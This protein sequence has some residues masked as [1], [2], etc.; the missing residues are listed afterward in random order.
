MIVLLQ[1][2]K[3]S[4]VEFKY[5]DKWGYVCSAGGDDTWNWDLF[6]ENAGDIRFLYIKGN[7]QGS[8]TE[9]PDRIFELQKLIYLELVGCKIGN[10]IERLS[11]LKSLQYLA[12]DDSELEA[13]PDDMGDLQEL[14]ALSLLEIKVDKNGIPQSLARLKGLRFFRIGGSF[15]FPEEILELSE[16]QYLHIAL[17]KMEELPEKVGNLYKLCLLYTS[18][19][20]DD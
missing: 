7:V 10:G 20:A 12:L 18:D 14:V 13:L 17:S 5:D 3:G 1:H 16:L 4:T 8:G 11:C 9:I 6:L 19:A 2:K 15:L